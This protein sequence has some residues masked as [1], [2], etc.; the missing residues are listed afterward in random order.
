MAASES[1]PWRPLELE[2]SWLAAWEQR[3]TG[4]SPPEQAAA[5]LRTPQI[6]GEAEEGTHQQLGLAQ[7]GRRALESTGDAE[8]GASK[9]EGEAR[10]SNVHSP[11]EAVLGTP[12]R[13]ADAMP[14][15]QHRRE[16]LGDPVAGHRS[17]YLDDSDAEEPRHPPRQAQELRDG[18]GQQALGGQRRRG[19]APW[20]HSLAGGLAG[21]G[22]TA[23]LYPFDIVRTRMQG[24]GS[25]SPIR[26]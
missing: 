21:M 2:R 8:P 24:E 18:H 19:T 5:Q 3:R 6:R 15:T 13:R 12:Q 10:Q 1:F 22:T 4:C 7:L 23:L 16:Q 9:R 17:P 14:G 26:C 20:Q 25:I 11:G